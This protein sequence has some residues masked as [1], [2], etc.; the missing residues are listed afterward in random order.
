[1]CVCTCL[2][3]LVRKVFLHWEHWWGRSPV[4]VRLCRTSE[5]DL[6]N[7]FP[8]W[9]HANGPRLVL[10]FFGHCGQVS[11]WVRNVFSQV[12]QWCGLSPVWIL[13]WRVRLASWV[14]LFSQWEHRKGRWPL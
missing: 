12:L 9:A 11:P 14:K 6:A 1:M 7:L 4:W 3:S 13:S 8:Q 2:F 5:V 10:K